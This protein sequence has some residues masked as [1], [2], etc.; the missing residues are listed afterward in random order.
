MGMLGSYIGGK[1]GQIGNINLRVFGFQRVMERFWNI[2]S[3]HIA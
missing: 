2:H 3:V 1:Q